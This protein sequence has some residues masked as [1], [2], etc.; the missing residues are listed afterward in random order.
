MYSRDGLDWTLSPV[1]AANASIAFEGGA[2]VDV[3]RQR[4]KVLVSA[5]APQA[6]GVAITHIFHG[7]MHCGERTI[8]DAAS[9][10]R[11]RCTNSTWPTTSS[12]SASTSMHAAQPLTGSGGVGDGVGING[13]IGMDY[14]FTTVVPLAS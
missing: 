8:T 10:P 14:S 4:P 13:P 11:N 3:F 7:A 6:K 1:A 9:A 5:P 2:S 12:T